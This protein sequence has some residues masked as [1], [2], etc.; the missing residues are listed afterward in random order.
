MTCRPTAATRNRTRPGCTIPTATSGKSS[1]FSRTTCRK[2]R[3]RNPRVARRVFD[4]HQVLAFL[5]AVCVLVIVPGPNTMIILAH[6]LLGR[7]A[8][9]ATVAGVELGTLIHTT[10]VA[11]GLSALL[12]ASPYALIVVKFA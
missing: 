8:G 9:L 7:V 12:A 5:A 4:A 11:L 3:P 2:H 6:S 1:S 10:A